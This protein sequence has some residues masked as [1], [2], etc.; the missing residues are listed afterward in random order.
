VVDVIP[1]KIQRFYFRDGGLSETGRRAGGALLVVLASAAVLLFTTWREHRGQAAG[2]TAEE[3]RRPMADLALMDVN[4]GTWRLR[5]HRGE[6]VAVNLWATWCGPC[7]EETPAIVRVVRDLGP[8][9]FVVIGVSLDEGDREAK[10]R[11]FS[12]RYGVNYPMGFPDAMSQMSAG[13]EGIPTTLLVDRKGRVAKVYVGE[14][15]ESV[16]RTDAGTLLE[17]R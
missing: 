16:L 8:K 9:G 1:F 13:L 5:D 12:E 4:G 3:S 6:V 11:A 17:E 2:V 7:R 10:V 14:M 15:R